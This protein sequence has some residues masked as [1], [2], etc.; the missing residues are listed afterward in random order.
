MS[1][2]TAPA[3]VTTGRFAPT[4][5]RAQVVFGT[6]YSRP[7]WTPAPLPGRFRIH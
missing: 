2:V 7:R 1:T 5:A 3:G 6:G 4:A